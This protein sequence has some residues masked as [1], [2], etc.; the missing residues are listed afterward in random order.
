MDTLDDLVPSVKNVVARPGTFATLFPETTDDD[1]VLVLRD[2]LAEA[3][4]QGLLTK[5]DATEDGALVD[6]ADETLSVDI[7]NAAGA[8]VVLF[9]GARLITAELLNRAYSRRYKAGAVEFEE[10]Q[11]ANLL[12]DVLRGLEA[13]KAGVIAVA[14]QA[15][16][17]ASGAAFHMAD[18]AGVRD[19][20]IDRY[21]D[22]LT[23]W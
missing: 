17:S 8:I 1:L 5:V 16:N 11:S 13:R 2:G 7:S 23:G 6:A 14:T 18:I 9:G 15:A 12:Q 3:Q 20:G 21:L 10:V 4:L 19:L 22:P